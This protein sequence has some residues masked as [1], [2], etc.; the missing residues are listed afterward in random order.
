MPVDTACG[1][2]Q[3]A[4]E[5]ADGGR[6]D[7]FATLRGPEALGF[8]TV[9]DPAG[10]DAL[11][12]EIADPLGQFQVVAELIQP[13]DRADDLS[14]RSGPASRCVTRRHNASAIAMNRKMGFVD[15][16]D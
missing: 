14:R 9:G 2:G 7:P 3:A 13:L 10:A 11:A 6:G 12:C 1:A 4:H 15:A 8:Q 16:V 5:V